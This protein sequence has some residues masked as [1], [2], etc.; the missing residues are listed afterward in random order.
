MHI[1]ILGQTNATDPNRDYHDSAIAAYRREGGQ[2]GELR[3]IK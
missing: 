3:E 2:M 1:R